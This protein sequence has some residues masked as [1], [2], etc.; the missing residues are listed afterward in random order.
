[1]AFK[2]S[3]VRFSYAPQKYRKAGLSTSFSIFLREH[4]SYP[5][6]SRCPSGRWGTYPPDP[7]RR[8]APE[9]GCWSVDQLFYIFAGASV[10]PPRFALPLG[11]LGDVSPRPPASLRSRRRMLVCRPAF[12][13]FCGSIRPTPALRAAP[14]GAGGRIPQTPCVAPLQK[15]DAGLSTSFSIFLREHPLLSL[16]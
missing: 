11:A 7:L 10:L 13:Y 3:G 15:K 2:R 9:E 6:A 16:Y 12:L 8:S 4:P 14:R 5:R 1:M